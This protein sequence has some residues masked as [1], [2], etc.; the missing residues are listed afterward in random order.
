MKKEE[1]DDEDEDEDERTP[2]S[3]LLLFFFFRRVLLEESL[4]FLSFVFLGFSQLFVSHRFSQ[5]CLAPAYSRLV[6][7]TEVLE[8]F[9]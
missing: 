9:S 4:F 7:Q 3:M 8:P 1:E 6:C 2:F 5:S